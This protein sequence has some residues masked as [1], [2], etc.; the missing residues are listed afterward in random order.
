MSLSKI[1]TIKKSGNEYFHI[2]GKAIDTTLLSFWRWMSS[3][4]LSNALRGVLAEYIVSI[5]VGC[6]N[7][8]RAEWDAYG[9]TSPT[10]I[11]IEVKSGAYLQSWNQ[12]EL[13]KISF[14][15]QKTYY[16]DPDTNLQSDILKRQA[17]VYVF[18]VLG[19]KDKSTVDPMNF[20]QWEFYVLSTDTLNDRVGNQKTIGLSSLLNLQPVQCKFGEIGA[21]ICQVFR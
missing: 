18:C 21:A 7:S 5:D 19:H 12:K 9:L 3:E 17:D 4:L 6:E 2:D 15:I 1:T 8:A 14:G 20:G 10:G 13:S 16:V 11:K